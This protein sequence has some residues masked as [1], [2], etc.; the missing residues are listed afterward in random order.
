MALSTYLL[1]T[2]TCVYTAEAQYGSPSA[3]STSSYDSGSSG[4]TAASGY[5]NKISISTTITTT[6]APVTVT[7]S[8]ATATTVNPL[9][10][11]IEAC[12]AAGQIPGFRC[13]F[14]GGG[15]PA[16]DLTCDRSCARD[17]V[18]SVPCSPNGTQ[19][20]RCL[21]QNNNGTGFPS[22]PRSGCTYTFLGTTSPL[23]CPQ[24][25]V[26]ARGLR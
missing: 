6:T 20:E 12:I 9:Q 22:L 18:L 1:I 17:P 13:S 4:S 26:P 15:T 10:A 24:I 14:N 11:Q 5:G 3:G 25:C 23:T 21:C 19:I 8:T 16:P 2:Y 7:Y